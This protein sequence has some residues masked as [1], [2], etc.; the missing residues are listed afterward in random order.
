MTVPVSAGQH[1]VSLRVER[2]YAPQET[3]AYDQSNLTAMFV[4]RPPRHPLSPTLWPV[5]VVVVS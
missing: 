5:R 4:P 2:G 1:K 3:W